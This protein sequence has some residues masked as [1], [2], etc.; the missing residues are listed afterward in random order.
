MDAFASSPLDLPQ[1]AMSLDALACG[2]VLVNRSGIIAHAN[3]QLGELIGRPPADLVGI[4]L[5]SLY[6]AGET[7]E[8]M[9]TVLRDFDRPRRRRVLS[10]TER[11]RSASGHFQSPGP[12]GTDRF[13]RTLPSSR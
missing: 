8:V 7:C 12:S 11:R 10:A 1:I 6:P 9:R 5:P 2:A 3:A 4:T 13:C